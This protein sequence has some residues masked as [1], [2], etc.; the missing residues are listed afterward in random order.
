MK[1]RSLRSWVDL[2]RKPEG[3]RLTR[4][5]LMGCLISSL[6]VTG[7]TAAETPGLK[8]GANTGNPAAPFF[9]DL[10]GLDFKT[11][12]P[13]RNPRNPKY[14]R[15]AELPDGVLPSSNARGNF[16]IGPTHPPGPETV[17][18]DVPHGRV[19]NFIMSSA[20]SVI[21]NPGLIRDAPLESDPSRMASRR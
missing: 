15:A 4:R 16:I 3:I 6:P 20:D 11:S 18:Q 1:L 17:V 13:T 14:P 19:L 2:L 21:F 8:P 9:V 7:V 5:V 10:S 12:P